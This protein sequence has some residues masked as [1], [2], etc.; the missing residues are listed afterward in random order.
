LAKASAKSQEAISRFGQKQLDFLPQAAYLQVY[1]LFGV[2]PMAIALDFQPQTGR[3]MPV[4][5]EW[6]LTGNWPPQG[7]WTYEDYCRLPED[8][9]VYEVIEGELFMSPAPRP[10]HQKC[11]GNLFAA[12]RDFGIKHDAGEAFYPPI[13]VILPGLATPVQPDVIFIAKERLDIVKEEQVEGAPDIIVEVLSPWNWIVDRRKKFQTYAKAGV[14]EYWIV[15]PKARTIELFGLLGVTY[16]LIGKHG[17][18][19]IVR[20]EVLQRFEVKVEEVCPA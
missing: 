19:E 5:Y 20:S 15:D 3:V 11:G 2:N 4:E 8:G 18:G 12:F 10:K 6:P 17:V 14:R 13:D 1:L 7:E 9:W 16:A